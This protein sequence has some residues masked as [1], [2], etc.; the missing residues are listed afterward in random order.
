MESTILLRAYCSFQYLKIP[1]SI[2][3]QRSKFILELNPSQSGYWTC[4]MAF[5]RFSVAKFLLSVIPVYVGD[6]LGLLSST[7]QTAGAHR[8]PSI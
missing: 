3:P 5:T 7:P 2:R 1:V 8:L 4:D 6:P